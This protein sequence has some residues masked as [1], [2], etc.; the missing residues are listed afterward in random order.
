M[1]FGGWDEF[2]SQDGTRGGVWEGAWNGTPMGPS[3]VTVTR[4]SVPSPSPL[5]LTHLSVQVPPPLPQVLHMT[6]GTDTVVAEGQ[7]VTVNG[8]AVPEG[9]PYL[10]KGEVPKATGLGQGGDE[11]SVTSGITRTR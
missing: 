3:L 5:S 6:F 11:P 9:R 8:A 7:N 2:G 1:G 4:V 10:H